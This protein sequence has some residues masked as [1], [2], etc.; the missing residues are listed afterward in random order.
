MHYRIDPQRF[1][2]LFTAWR[3][4]KARE[5][6]SSMRP[7]AFDVAALASDIGVPPENFRHVVTGHVLVAEITLVS[8][9]DEL[10]CSAQDLIMHRSGG[11]ELTSDQPISSRRPSHICASALGW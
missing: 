6:R 4:R 9:S 8:L 1:G 7:E 3:R 2:P 5:R 10:G 11:R